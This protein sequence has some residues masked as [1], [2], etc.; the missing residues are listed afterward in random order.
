MVDKAKIEQIVSETMGANAEIQGIVVCDAKGK[1][2][3]GHTISD[4]VNQDDIAKLIV[5]ISVNSSQLVAGIDMGGLK[6]MTIAAEQGYVFI[7]GDV[8]M[9]LAGLA[10]EGAREQAGLIRMALKRA[11]VSMLE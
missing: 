11:L 4:G 6:E 3:F 1:V 10:G 2:I 9:I 5:K 8:K 7:L